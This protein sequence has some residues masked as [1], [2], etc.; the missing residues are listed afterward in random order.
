MEKEMSFFNS[1][2]VYSSM[3]PGFLGCEVLTTKLTRILF[4]HIRHNLPDIVSEIR[5]K[6]KETQLELEDL[7]EPMP[8]NRGEKLHMVWAMI[9]EFVQSYKNQISGKFDAKKRVDQSGMGPQTQQ[10]SAGSKIKMQF[11]GLYSEFEQF[12]ATQ[13]YSD[14]AIERA[15]AMHEGDQIPGFPS[16]DVLQYLIAPQLDKLRDPALELIQDSYAQLEA[17]ASSIVE[18]IFMRCPTL[19]PEIM[20]IIVQVLQRERDHCRELVE[21][22]IDSEQNYMFVNDADYKENRTS[23]VP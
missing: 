17:L 9:T 16:V 22:V 5:E 12:N 7:G 10:L 3:P 2:P 15:I 8:N 23:I 1:H 4:T 20:D 11:Y 18:R 14:M 19:R 13:E 21:A 6:L